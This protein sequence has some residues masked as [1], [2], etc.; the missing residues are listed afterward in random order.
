MDK[1]AYWELYRGMAVIHNP[2]EALGVLFDFGV[3][4]V[5]PCKLMELERAYICLDSLFGIF[6]VIF[7]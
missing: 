2:S 6:K 4:N 7:L 1:K 5:L 3:K